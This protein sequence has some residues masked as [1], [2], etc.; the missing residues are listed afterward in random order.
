MSFKSLI[1]FKE[2][3]PEAGEMSNERRKAKADEKILKVIDL[4]KGVS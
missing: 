3:S 2:T 4:S 1:Q